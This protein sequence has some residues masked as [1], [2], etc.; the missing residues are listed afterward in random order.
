[1]SEHIEQAEL[2]ISKHLIK[3]QNPVIEMIPPGPDTPMKRFRKTWTKAERA[4]ELGEWD[5]ARVAQY[6]QCSASGLAALFHSIDDASTKT[7]MAFAQRMREAGADEL[8]FNVDF[9]G[10]KFMVARES[11]S[12]S[13][14][15]MEGE[16]FEEPEPLGEDQTQTE[17]EAVAAPA[18]PT[19]EKLG[20]I[21][22][23]PAGCLALYDQIRALFSDE[24]GTQSARD[25][26]L[27]LMHLEMLSARNAALSKGMLVGM[28]DADEKQSLNAVIECRRIETALVAHPPSKQRM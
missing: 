7:L 26:A 25:T 13:L 18:I 5:R 27:F 10:S 21:W 11:Y 14:R 2:G 28:R 3:R 22:D 1:M 6:I 19:A 4:T 20:S 15:V 12:G 16:V 23:D 17:S 24:P 9:A 8:R